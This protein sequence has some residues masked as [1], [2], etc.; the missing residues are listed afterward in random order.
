MRNYEKL[1]L[2]SFALLLLAGC[3]QKET[4]AAS[5]EQHLTPSNQLLPVLDNAER[6]RLSPRPCSDAEAKNG[7]QQTQTII[8]AI[9]F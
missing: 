5:K 4:P 2:V 1:L 7:T 6:I 8:K 3:G 9:K